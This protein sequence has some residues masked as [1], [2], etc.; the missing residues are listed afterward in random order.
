MNCIVK[1]AVATLVAATG[2]GLAMPA[3][4]A[5]EAPAGLPSARHASCPFHRIDM[6][7]GGHIIYSECHLSSGVQVWG[8]IW[9]D[10]ADGHC[11]MVEVNFNHGGYR[12][13][14][15]CG[16]GNHK[17]FHWSQ[18]GATDAYVTGRIV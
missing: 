16:K 6:G 11:A 7:S 1:R 5:A 15:V 18:G 10:K 9:D 12:Y 4:A 2:L 14:K 13:M 8:T 17:D 3:V